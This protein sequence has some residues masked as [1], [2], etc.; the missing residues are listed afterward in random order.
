M[1]DIGNN[2]GNDSNDN[3][4]NNTNN[5]SKGKK[6]W[7]AKLKI[8]RRK[9]ISKDTVTTS[10]S[11]S[12]T[13]ANRPLAGPPMGGGHIAEQVQK[14][15]DRVAIESQERDRIGDKAEKRE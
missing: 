11:V 12:N 2:S 9:D 1:A 13:G 5:S 6:S 8:T 4:N 15:R 14:E 10:T 3:N 7:K